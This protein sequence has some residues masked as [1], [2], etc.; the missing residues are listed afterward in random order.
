[1]S[2]TATGRP[3]AYR[4]GPVSWTPLEAFADE[5]SPPWSEV[6]AKRQTRNPPA[7]RPAKSKTLRG[8]ASSSGASECEGGGRRSPDEPPSRPRAAHATANSLP[9]RSKRSEKASAGGKNEW[10]APRRP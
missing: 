9:V 8:T 5:C 1:M 10:S 6:H 4:V 3:Q 2:R 7:N